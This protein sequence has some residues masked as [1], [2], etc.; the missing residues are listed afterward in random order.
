[1]LL[2][3]AICG[4]ASGPRI[5]STWKPAEPAASIVVIPAFNEPT[6]ELDVSL[7]EAF[8]D[9]PLKVVPVKALR[10]KLVSDED[11]R[12]ML[13][14]I[15]A[16][17]TVDGDLSSAPKLS[18]FLGDTRFAIL[19]HELGDADLAVFPVSLRVASSIGWTY[20][21]GMCRLY[22]LRTGELVAETKRELQLNNTGAD[23]RNQLFVI[24]AAMVRND[25][26]RHPR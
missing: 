14:E 23:A 22:D 2:C 3:V 16:R 7:A 19:R 21:Q 26:Q 11:V 5:N 18:T 20:V 9:P 25:F 8:D 13:L 4:C 15:A 6:G 10:E 1:L 24:L 12:K 17:T